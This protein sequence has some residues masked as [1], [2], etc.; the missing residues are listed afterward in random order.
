MRLSALKEK[1]E[2]VS[3][4]A[5]VPL[6]AESEAESLGVVIVCLPHFI[7]GNIQTQRLI[8]PSLVRNYRT[9]TKT[10]P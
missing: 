10:I 6:N 2:L 7:G 3:I 9:W 4:I 1:E 5:S 8:V